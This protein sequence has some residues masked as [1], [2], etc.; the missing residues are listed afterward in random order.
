MAVLFSA[1]LSLNEQTPKRAESAPSLNIFSTMHYRW[2]IVSNNNATFR[3]MPCISQ[4]KGLD[5]YYG[6]DTTMTFNGRSFPKRY[7]IDVQLFQYNGN[8]NQNWIFINTSNAV[9]ATYMSNLAGY[10]TQYFNAAT[11]LA[12]GLGSIAPCAKLTDSSPTDMWKLMQSSG[13]FLYT[14]HGAPTFVDCSGGSAS[15]TRDYVL[16]QPTGS[17]SNCRLVVYL[18]CQAGQGG[19]GGDNLAQATVDRGAKTVVAFQTNIDSIKSDTWLK[20]FCDAI[21]GGQS[22]YQAKN[23]ALQYVKNVHGQNNTGYT[24]T[25]TIFGSYGQ[26][27]N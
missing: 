27:F 9:T 16:S 2:R 3:I 25:A 15:L 24:E 14:G 10:S 20:G 8:T 18:T 17:L 6:T 19:V 5:V 22:V 26:T 21:I 12:N 7:G 4:D 1:F 23:A 13:I 11:D